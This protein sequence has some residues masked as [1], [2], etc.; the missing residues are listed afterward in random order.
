MAPQISQRDWIVWSDDVDSYER[1]W[2][3]R[4]SPA[5]PW[6]LEQVLILAE[7]LCMALLRI[8]IDNGNV[9][10]GQP[11]VQQR[12]TNVVVLAEYRR[13]VRLRRI[14]GE[15]RTPRKSDSPSSSVASS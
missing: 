7:Q 8:G 3:S 1:A 6:L 10:R 13:P 2:R 12:P 15:I 14:A 5:R 9:V 4:L 11:F